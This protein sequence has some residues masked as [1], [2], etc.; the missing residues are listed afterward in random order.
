M[1]DRRRKAP[2]LPVYA[3][4]AA[5]FVA[6]VGFLGTR[7]TDGR[8]PRLGGPRTAPAA[9]ITVRRVIVSRHLVELGRPTRSGHDE[10]YATV[11]DWHAARPRG[12]APLTTLASP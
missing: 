10:R 4:V 11:S 7:V 1:T 9:H 3:T 5:L 12:G 8:D 6:T 2:V